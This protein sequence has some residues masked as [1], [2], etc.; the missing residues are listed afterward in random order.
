M[1]STAVPGLQQLKPV[2]MEAG[3]G[4]SMGQNST[5]SDSS[6]SPIHFA[7]SWSLTRSDRARQ[8]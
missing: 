3:Q 2:V 6:I 1:S 7:I 8:S 4:W 5:P